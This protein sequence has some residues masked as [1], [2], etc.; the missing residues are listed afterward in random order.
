MIDIYLLFIITIFWCIFI[1]ILFYED[2]IHIQE[3]QQRLENI[4]KVVSNEKTKNKI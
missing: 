4:E 1:S 2:R 3:I